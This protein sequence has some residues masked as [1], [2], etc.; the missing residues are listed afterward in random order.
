MATVIILHE[1]DDVE[2]WLASP[3][4]DETFGPLGMT[5]RT[6]IDPAKSNRVGL[7]VDVPDM[8]TF[9]RT[10]ESEVAADAM[11]SDGVRTDTVV[12]LVES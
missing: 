2:H 7:T 11:S 5:V 8:E 9:Q 12:L 6:F 1:V 4:R 3:L 10:M